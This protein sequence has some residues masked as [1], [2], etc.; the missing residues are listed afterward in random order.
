MEQTTPFIQGLADLDSAAAILADRTRRGIYLFIKHRREPVSVN[1]VADAFSI[2][3]NAAKFHLDKLLECGL[4]QAEFKRVNGRSGPGAGRPSKLYSSTS[5]EV[6]F[7]IPERRYELLAQL[8]LRALTSGESL[9]AVGYAF[10][11]QLAVDFK[12][13]VQC[14]DPMDCVRSLLSQLGFEPTV[15][16]DADGATWITTEN[17]PFGKVAL[18]SDVQ[19]CGLD[20]AMI[21]GIMETF[22]DGE[23]AVRECMSMPHGH[24]ICVREVRWR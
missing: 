19:V 21:R 20:H 18:E 14:E 9:E 13:D 15:E 6:S 8:L 16:T 12:K 23:V 2:H 1:Q 24:E 17:C 11:R 4:L 3:R 22:A 10:G 7:S 5:V